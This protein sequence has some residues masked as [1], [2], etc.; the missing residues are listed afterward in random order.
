MDKTPL[1]LIDADDTIWESALYFRRAEEDFVSLMEALGHA[2]D[3]VVDTVHARDI[4]RLD[5]T[6]YGAVPYMD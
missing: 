1:L 6:G 5:H 2:P 3:E 4:E